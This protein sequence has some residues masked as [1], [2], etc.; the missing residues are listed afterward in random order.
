MASPQR[1]LA[2]FNNGRP[3]RRFPDFKLLPFHGRLTEMLTAVVIT[4]FHLDHCAALPYLTEVCV[5]CMTCVN[6]ESWL[7]EEAAQ[8]LFNVMMKRPGSCLKERT[9]RGMP[10]H[11]A[12]SCSCSHLPL[13]GQVHGYQGP[14][15]MTHPTK[16]IMPVMLEDYWKVGGRVGSKE[17]RSTTLPRILP[18]LQSH[19][20]PFCHRCIMDG[21]KHIEGTKGSRGLMH[22]VP[23]RCSNHAS[24]Q[25][26]PHLTILQV[27]AER[28]G[29][30]QWYGRQDI[31]ACMRKAVAV[32][33]NQAVTVCDHHVA[34]TVVMRMRHSLHACVAA[35]IS[36]ATTST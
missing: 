3:T 30:R 15:Y 11:S 8:P 31:G 14:I 26:C 10:C 29:D 32:D 25:T 17:R 9:A 21:R 22:A 35:A 20:P 7:W 6:S 16:A 18:V 34:H 1:Q 5:A 4:H 27:M 36:H 28:Q 2:F 12:R 24:L 13:H 23:C 19:V 33:L